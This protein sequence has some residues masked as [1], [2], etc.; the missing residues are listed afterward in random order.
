MVKVY[1]G[2]TASLLWETNED[3]NAAS[4][5]HTSFLHSEIV[6]WHRGEALFADDYKTRVKS[7]KQGT[8]W[9]F[10]LNGV[11]ESDALNY[12]FTVQGGPTSFDATIY[13]FSKLLF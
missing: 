6:V 4:V 5:F 11:M 1:V 9:G 3:A 2:S 13:V 7:L 12:I 8:T 10:A